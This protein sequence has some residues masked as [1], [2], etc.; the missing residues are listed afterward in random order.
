MNQNTQRSQ[1]EKKMNKIKG[2]AKEM[3]V[4]VSQ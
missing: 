3:A 2:D 1:G 4:M